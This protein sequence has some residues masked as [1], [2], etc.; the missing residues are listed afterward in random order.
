LEA[1]LVG[2]ILNDPSRLGLIDRIVTAADFGDAIHQRLY[3]NFAAAHAQGRLIDVRLAIAALGMNGAVAITPGLT[4]SQYIARLAAEAT[5]TLLVIDYARAIRELADKRRLEDIADRIKAAVRGTR[6]AKDIATEV[7]EDADAIAVS[8]ALSHVAPITMREAN[9]LSVERMTLRM[10]NPG[11]ITGITTG[12]RDLDERT[13]GFQR[14]K[15]TYLAG[16]PGMGKSA[17]AV[18]SVKEG[19]AAGHEAIFF[20]LEMSA[21]DLSDRYLADAVYEERDP[22]HYSD[23]AAGKVDI[24]QVQRVIDAQRDFRGADVMI[25][26]QG[27]LTIAQITF[28]AR[29]YQKILERRGKRLDAVWVDHLHKVRPSDRNAGNPTAEITEISGALMVL[30]KEMNVAVIAA[31]QLNR[32]TEERDGHRPTLADLRQSGS[33]EQDAD[34]VLMLYREAYYLKDPCTDRSKE[35]DRLAR[36]EEVKNLIE[37]KIEK[38]R[39]GPMCTVPLFCN[40]AANHFRNLDKRHG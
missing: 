28:R 39:Q 6:A 32:A 13:G 5:G 35:N 16:R 27:G 26:P 30:A 37:V 14:G 10:Q 40:I 31:A 2:A 22:I 17:L 8:Q 21:E 33:I 29:K 3:E 18:A 23:I 38:N 34:L 19:A 12:F 4:A 1:A 7:I 25:D 24:L 15:L 11:C 20:S 36:L 9:E